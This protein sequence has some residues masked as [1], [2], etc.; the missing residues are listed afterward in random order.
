MHQ[1]LVVGTLQT[2]GRHKTPQ[3]SHFGR[4]YVNKVGGATSNY[5]TPPCAAALLCPAFLVTKLRNETV[6][7]DDDRQIQ[8]RAG[9]HKV[10]GAVIHYARQ[11]QVDLEVLE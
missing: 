8:V 3:V 5:C 2:W 11:Q 9:Q 6:R 7:S 1:P 10:Q 4:A